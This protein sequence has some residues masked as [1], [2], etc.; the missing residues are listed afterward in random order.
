MLHSITH[1]LGVTD[2]NVIDGDTLNSDR[3][4]EHR[5][6]GFTVCVFQTYEVFILQSSAL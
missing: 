5:I 6:S 3:L 1:K 4:V 2:G